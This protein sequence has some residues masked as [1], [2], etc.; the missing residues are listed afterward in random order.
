MSK[1]DLVH[2]LDITVCPILDQLNKISAD[3]SKFDQ[4]NPLHYNLHEETQRRTRE[5][6]SR[7]MFDSEVRE[8]Y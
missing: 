3:L 4:E 2:R 8:K 6:T 5:T 1:N 7:A